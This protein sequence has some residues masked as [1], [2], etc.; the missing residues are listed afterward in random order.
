MSDAKHSTVTYTSISSD[1]GS[2]DVGSSG[3]IVLG[4]DVLPMIPED[5]YAYVEA[6]MQEPPPPNFVPEPVCPEFMPPEDDVLP[7][8]EQPL[9]TAFSTTADSPE[10]SSGD[11]ANNEEED[12]DE[13]KEEEHSARADSIPPP[14]VHR[15][16]TRISIPSQALV[17]FLSEAEVE[18]LLALPTP[19]P[20]LLTPSPLPQLSSSPLPASP[21][22]PLGYRAAMIRLRA[23]SP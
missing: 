8:E 20:S 22:Y 11:D 21:T 15:T 13:D 5:P 7:A 14:P 23:E 9:P 17:L 2:S 4:H 18:R 16:T 6:A 10:E 12:E 3:V 1:D 19:P